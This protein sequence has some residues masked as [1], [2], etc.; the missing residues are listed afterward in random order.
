MMA[1]DYISSNSNGQIIVKTKKRKYKE[2]NFPVLKKSKRNRKIF[3]RNSLFEFP[4]LKWTMPTAK[5]VSD[6]LKKKYK[7]PSDSL[8]PID[9]IDWSSSSIPNIEIKDVELSPKIM[10]RPQIDY[11]YPEQKTA[12]Q[13]QV[14]K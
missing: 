13:P 14:K 12:P 3:R 1:K 5:Q 8:K 6:A 7:L 4:D 10:I 2:K 9:S 11:Q